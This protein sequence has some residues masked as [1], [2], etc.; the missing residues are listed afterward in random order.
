MDA[1]EQSQIGRILTHEFDLALRGTQ[2]DM[3][4][5]LA[6]NSAKGSLRSGATV[7]QVTQKIS[8]RY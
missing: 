2:Q 8:E 1:I 6:A 4:A 7:I 3:S 5:I